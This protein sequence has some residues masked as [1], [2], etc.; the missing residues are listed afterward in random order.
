MPNEYFS[1]LFCSLLFFT[2]KQRL[3]VSQLIENYLPNEYF[4]LKFSLPLLVASKQRLR[5]SQLIEHHMP[6]EYFLLKFSL[7]LL[8][9]SK[10]RLR[11]VLVIKDYMSYAYFSRLLYSPL[12]L[13]SGKICEPRIAL[14]R[15]GGWM[16]GSASCMISYS[17]FVYSKVLSSSLSIFRRSHRKR[18]IIIRILHKY[19]IRIKSQ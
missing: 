9:N 14:K 19:F 12:L 5:V 4:S 13:T 18:T 17:L 1:I 8:P 16:F 15:R 3:R 10:Q 7:P 2:S 11:V 6:N